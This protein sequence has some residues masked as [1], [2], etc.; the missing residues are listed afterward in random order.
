MNK[1]ILCGF[2]G[3]FLVGC[4]S[5]P[6]QVPKFPNPPEILMVPAPELTKL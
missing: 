3:M 6:I 1:F 2:L 5:K 4:S